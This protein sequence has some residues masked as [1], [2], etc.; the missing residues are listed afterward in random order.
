MVSLS[1]SRCLPPPQIRQPTQGWL[2]I[3]PPRPRSERLPHIEFHRDKHI[4]R[5]PYRIS[6]SFSRTICHWFV[7]AARPSRDRMLAS[8]LN[9]A[10]G[11]FGY[12]FERQYQQSIT[13]ED[14]GVCEYLRDLT[15]SRPEHHSGQQHPRALQHVRCPRESDV[16]SPAYCTTCSCPNAWCPNRGG[17]A[18]WFVSQ[19]ARRHAHT[20]PI[21]DTPR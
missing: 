18:S 21:N 8:A 10:I 7:I 19:W 15:T 11:F 2:A 17:R 16:K 9:F 1:R 4:A 13:I 20:L 5:V 6:V 14:I 12:P 3:S